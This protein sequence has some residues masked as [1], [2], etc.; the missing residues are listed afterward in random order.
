[1]RHFLLEPLAIT[2][3]ARGVGM[4]TTTGRGVSTRGAAQGLSARFLSTAVE[5]ITVAAITSAADHDLAV[6]ASAVEE[7]G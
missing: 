5:A 4:T 6:T 7:A 1:M 2:T 3:L